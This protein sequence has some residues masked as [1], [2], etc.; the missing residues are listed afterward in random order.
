MSTT[1]ERDLYSYG[2]R[3]G[4]LRVELINHFSS[5]ITLPTPSS[6]G[7]PASSSFQVF[8]LS[9]HLLDW[10]L[11]GQH[12]LGAQ[13]SISA[14]FSQIANVKHS[15]CR[16]MTRAWFCCADSSVIAIICIAHIGCSQS[17]WIIG[18]VPS[19]HLR[20]PPYMWGQP[21]FVPNHAADP[22]NIF[23]HCKSH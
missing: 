17:K 9:F 7:C 5:H 18:F 19:K 21:V 14:D 8:P 12:S 22:C 15:L 3:G 10:S 23:A 2:R 16:F 4:I 11:S 20:W 1:E 6:H 13:L